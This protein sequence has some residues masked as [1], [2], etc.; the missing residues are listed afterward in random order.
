MLFRSPLIW[1]DAICINQND[2]V[3]KSVQVPRMSDI[4]GKC[5]H[6]L[7][8][9]GPV[10]NE[11]QDSICKLAEKLRDFKSPGTED[12]AEDERIKSF[13][14]L[15]KSDEESAADVELVRK[16]LKSIG[17]RPWF[18]R[19]WIL[20]EAV[21]AQ[22]SPILLCGKYELGY[23]I[24]FKTWVLMLD[25]S[26][27]GQLL[28]SFMA[29]NPVRFK[30]IEVTYKRILRERGSKDRKSTRLNSSHSGESR[31]PSSA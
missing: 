12:L 13:M 31:M 3:E 21:L 29:E 14:K 19:I 2:N 7:A 24:F 25:P 18:R 1:V 17:H 16:A 10:E 23:D 9:L 27:D 30:A 20:Q 8:W 28:Y 15:G 6:V 22:R 11:D 5:Q 4:Y 26:E